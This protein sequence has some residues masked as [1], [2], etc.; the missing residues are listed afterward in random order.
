MNTKGEMVVNC[1][2]PHA[3]VHMHLDKTFLISVLIVV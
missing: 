2:S 3:D 1:I